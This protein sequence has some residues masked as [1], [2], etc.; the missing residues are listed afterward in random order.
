MVW[1]DVVR[2]PIF[3]VKIG[4]IK[5]CE[6]NNQTKCNFPVKRQ[7]NLLDWRWKTVFCQMWFQL[8]FLKQSD[9]KYV[10]ELVGKNVLGKF[11]RTAVVKLLIISEQVDFKEINKNREVLLFDIQKGMIHRKGKFFNTG[12]KNIEKNK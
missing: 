7:K 8:A 12:Q 5:Y 3:P 4:K 1:Y 9:T 10:H 6:F 11:K 2:T